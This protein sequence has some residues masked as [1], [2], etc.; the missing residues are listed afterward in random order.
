MKLRSAALVCGA[1]ILFSG[2]A[3][4]AAGPALPVSPNGLPMEAIWDLAPGVTRG[5]LAETGPYYVSRWGD[6]VLRGRWENGEI[7]TALSRVQCGKDR[8]PATRVTLL[9][10]PP[11]DLCEG[12]G[13]VEPGSTQ[14]RGGGRLQLYGLSTGW[15]VIE[16]AQIVGQTHFLNGFL[17]G[18]EGR[19]G[20]SRYGA[21][22]RSQGGRRIF[23]AP[24][25]VVAL[26]DKVSF[27]V[28]RGMGEG[29]LRQLF[30][31][32]AASR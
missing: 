5:R 1:T 3:A 13:V 27:T 11:S 31:A 23:Y 28:K 22:F 15:M 7:V 24:G 29:E 18:E 32:A 21:L 2:V 14:T 17:P 16:F 9:G 12:I 8:N 30:A 20:L 10:A 25:E 26:S 6:I 4:D 19:W